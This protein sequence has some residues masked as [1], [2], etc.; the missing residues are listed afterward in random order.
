MS[1]RHPLV[2]NNEFL[3]LIETTL[4]D[5]FIELHLICYDFTFHVLDFQQYTY[6]HKIV[7]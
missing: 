5:G 6:V 7:F 4:V 1:F 2:C 3:I